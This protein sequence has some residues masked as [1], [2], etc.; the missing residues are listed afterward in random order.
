MGNVSMNRLTKVFIY[1]FLVLFAFVPVILHFCDFLV[2]C[3]LFAVALFVLFLVK[4]DKMNFAVKLFLS[5]LAIRL[6]VA[7]T[8]QTPPQSDFALLLDASQRLNNGDMSFLDT[9]YFQKWDYQMGFV[10]FQSILLKIWNDTDFL[11]VVNCFFSAGNTL[12]I[13]LIAREFASRKSAKIASVL[14]CFLPFSVFYVTILSNQFSASFFS[15]LGLYLIISKGKMNEFLKYFIASVL[16]V[17]SNVLRPESIIPL[18]SILIYLVLSIRKGTC[19]NCLL[20]VSILVSTYF[21]LKLIIGKL[22][23]ITGIAPFGLS[24]NDPLWKFVLGFDHGS[25]GVYSDAGNFYATNEEALSLIQD[26]AFTYLHKLLY[27]FSNKINVFWSGS[28]TYWIF[29]PLLESGTYILRVNFPINGLAEFVKDYSFNISLAMY[30][31]LLIGMVAFIKKEPCNTKVL[32]IMSQVFIT[33]GVYLLIEVQARYIFHIQLSVF[34]LAALG[35][36]FLS[37]LFKNSKKKLLTY[38]DRKE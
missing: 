28:A 21:L 17:I 15:Y 27:L 9:V 14:Y 37:D 19:K 10:F 36:D 33:F 35:I 22:F 5:A 32:I 11:R 3:Y 6:V 31:L 29:G 1:T 13:Y 23:A 25:G 12:L 2:V 30:V 38:L 24:N 20:R 26:R 7:A 18:L 4:F 8:I 16:L 34:I